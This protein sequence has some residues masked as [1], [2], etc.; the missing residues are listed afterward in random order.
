MTLGFVHEII[1]EGKIVYCED[2]EVAPCKVNNITF[3][4]E[5]GIFKGNE[6]AMNGSANDVSNGAH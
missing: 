2:E 1:M 3:D 5:K 6:A 4:P